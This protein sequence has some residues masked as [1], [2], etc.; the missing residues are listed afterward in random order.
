[1]DIQSVV[2]MA[3]GSLLTVLSTVGAKAIDRR[4]RARGRLVTDLDLAHESRRYLWQLV[5]KLL[6]LGR[7]HGI[8]EDELG[9]YS[10]MVAQDPWKARKGDT[11]G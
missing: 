7:R 1:M 4:R 6:H 10:E 2:H 5:D 8:P 11:D 9:S 3:L